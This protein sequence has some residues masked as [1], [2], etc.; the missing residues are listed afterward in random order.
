MSHEEEDERKI[1][2]RQ[3]GELEHVKKKSSMYVGGKKPI[4][5]TEYVTAENGTEV[6]TKELKVSPAALK[7]VDEVIVN[8]IDRNTL[9]NKVN[10][11]VKVN[12]EKRSISIK[13]DN[14]CMPVF[15]NETSE[16]DKIQNVEML[17]T[18][19][20]AGS[21]FTENE[22]RTTGGTF[23]FGL[24]L[25]AAF[26]RK[27]IV[28]TVDRKSK[29][30][31]KKS[32]GCYYRQ[33]FLEGLTKITDPEIREVEEDEEQYTKFTFLLNYEEFGMTTGQQ[34]F[35]DFVAL[36]YMR[37][38]HTACYVTSAVYWN[39]VRM[40][41]KSC[42]D[43]ARDHLTPFYGDSEIPILETKLVCKK[44]KWQVVLSAK[45]EGK[46]PL[47]VSII[48]GIH[49][50]SGGTH[51]EYL[52][53]QINEG[54]REP[55]TKYIQKNY[56]KE[57]KF[58]AGTFDKYIFIMIVGDMV[59]PSFTG[60][61][62][63]KIDTSQDEFKGFE[64][65]R[66]DLSKY[67]DII[68][69]F[70]ELEFTEKN[71]DKVKGKTKTRLKAKKYLAAH[72]ATSKPQEIE[73][74]VVEGDSAFGMIEALINS[75]LFTGS[76]D[77]QSIYSIQGVPPNARKEV[78]FKKDPQ[79][80]KIIK[81]RSKKFKNHERINTLFD[82]AGLDP[83]E[84]Y[85]TSAARD[86]IKCKFIRI[87]TDQDEDGKGNIRSQ[88]VNTIQTMWPNLIKYGF[89]RFLV[90]PIIRA[91]HIKGKQAVQEFPSEEAFEQWKSN[92]DNVVNIDE[93][94]TVYYKGLGSHSEEEVEHMASQ[95]DSMTIKYIA[96][97]K[98]E[99]TCEIYFGAESDKRKKALVIPPEG[100]AEDYYKD[101]SITV[102]DDLN[103]ET[104]SYQIYNI[105]RHIPDGIDQ[106]MPSS[107]KALCGMRNRAKNNNQRIKV[108]QVTGMLTEKYNYH[109]GDSSMNSVIIGMN[110]SYPGSNEFPFFLA[111]S[112]FGTRKRGGQDAGQPRYIYTKLNKKLTDAMFPVDD[113]Y[114]L[115]YT[116]D[117]GKRGEPV[118]YIPIQP[119]AILE[120]NDQP[121]HGWANSTYARDYFEVSKHTRKC[122]EAG[123]FI[124]RKEDFSFSD[125]QFRHRLI[126]IKGVPNSVGV[127]KRKGDDGI[128]ITEMPYQC[129]NEN[130]INGSKKTK[131]ALAA[132]KKTKADDE[133]KSSIKKIPL[134]D[135]PNVV[136]VR[137]ESTNKDIKIDIKFKPGFLKKL[138]DS[139]KEDD[140][141]DPIIKYLKLKTS[142]K[143]N[144]N[145]RNLQGTVTEYKSYVDVM[146]DWFEVRKSFYEKRIKR[147]D[148]LLKLRI[149][150]A[151]NQIRFAENRHQYH[152]N[153]IKTNKQI[154]ILTEEKYQ[155]I[156]HALLDKPGY[157]AVNKL[158][159]LILNSEKSSFQYLLKMNS[160]DF[161]TE[162]IEHL[163]EYLK[164]CRKDKKKLYNE[165]NKFPGAHLWLE[166]LDILDS[167]VTTARE[168]TWHA[169]EVKPVWKFGEKK[170]TKRESKEA[171]ESED[172]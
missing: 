109:H 111:L 102:S 34:L 19:F 167:L 36:I 105:A 110:R 146:K 80:G 59:N 48:N 129:W 84:T 54:L 152:F 99:E 123:K 119:L 39:D 31:G 20:R 33:E 161:S 155:K 118:R 76:K 40:K 125:W 151:E 60:Q 85:E 58:K 108:Y 45:K 114:I 139:G 122:I 164:K 163:K 150:E 148:I 32:K 6:V 136:S 63:D 145:F 165:E 43:F 29:F 137:D 92:V 170:N 1:K 72:F 156:D 153:D 130:L 98:A 73:I 55:V 66:S 113:D 26:C 157:T 25:V 171:E 142:L 166:E 12:M 17:I 64:F 37:V 141:V 97:K 77:Y 13:N 133:V 149:I 144:L 95:W 82:I 107:R 47:Q 115:D 41:Q 91:F 53:D 2:Y 52:I 21:N 70:I 134:N 86:K 147:M 93:Y 159:E 126:N 88:L 89:V 15:I 106:M 51:V 10:I 143:P 18:K 3:M 112:Q 68:M 160:S 16:G 117:D 5:S 135:D 8:A 81:I 14:D 90:T 121:G 168:K 4:K 140:A 116:F 30:L 120:T 22:E 128:T 94:E 101:S 104:K 35:K 124:E 100:V 154:A 46:D 50:R 132:E 11:W 162:G 96:D 38:R 24:K 9:N 7:C 56:N 62:K 71:A 103:T 57:Y 138:L 79:T 61:R 65:S 87:C 172:D 23:G 78:K 28:E 131:K 44:L 67:Y 42:V 27:L 127:Y 169:W 74:N 49:C 83:A 158:E 69:P 75:K